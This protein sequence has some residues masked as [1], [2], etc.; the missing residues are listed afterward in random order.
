MATDE[1]NSEY[2][3]S[4]STECFEEAVFTEIRAK[5]ASAKESTYENSFY[6]GSELSMDMGSNK[7]D[8]TIATVI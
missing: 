2:A 8:T 3:G 5:S 6:V 7:P 1:A 4:V